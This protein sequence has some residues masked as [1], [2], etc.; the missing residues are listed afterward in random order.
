VF[1]LS[2]IPTNCFEGSL[3]LYTIKGE[4]KKARISLRREQ[5]VV[6]ISTLNVRFQGPRQVQVKRLEI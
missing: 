5:T 1:F 2:L 4:G 3:L 6:N